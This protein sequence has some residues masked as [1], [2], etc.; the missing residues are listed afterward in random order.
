MTNCASIIACPDMCNGICDISGIGSWIA[1]ILIIGVAVVIFF[2]VGYWSRR[3][4][5][6]DK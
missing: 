5:K 1:P 3:V 6:N 4:D 2:L